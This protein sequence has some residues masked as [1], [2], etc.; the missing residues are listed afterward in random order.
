[1][2]RNRDKTLGKWASSVPKRRRPTRE[3]R[4][5]AQVDWL[6]R[7]VSL[8]GPRPADP[9]N[10]PRK[11]V[12]EVLRCRKLMDGSVERTKALEAALRAAQAADPWKDRFKTYLSWIANDEA[13]EA[14]VRLVE[15]G[16]W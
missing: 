4:L 13:R 1:M 2:N 8:Q 7:S 16:C 10:I 11:V 15:C 14:F 3:D 5:L 12:A 9:P 6:L